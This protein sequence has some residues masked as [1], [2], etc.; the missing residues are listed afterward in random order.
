MLEGLPLKLGL[1]MVLT[2]DLAEAERFYGDVLGLKLK[3]KAAS[4]LIFDVDGTEFH[5]FRC[6]HA[7]PEH[8]HASSAATICVFEVPSL[9]LAM[10]RMKEDGVL[11]IHQTPAMNAHC[12]FRYAAFRGPGGNVHEIMERLGENRSP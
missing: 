3:D 4:Q 8:T 12:G 10:S 6:D 11:F 7:A 2:P 1:I 9:D 5:V